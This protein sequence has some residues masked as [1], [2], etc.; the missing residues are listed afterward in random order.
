MAPSPS[1]LTTKRSSALFSTRVPNP[2][3]IG[4]SSLDVESGSSQSA[5]T[6]NT[7]LSFIVFENSTVG[8]ASVIC[9]FVKTSVL[10]ASICSFDLFSGIFAYT[11]VDT[12]MCPF[13]P[14]KLDKSEDGL[15]LC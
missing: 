11:P 5:N 12:T 15:F 4:F 8:K 2:P 1:E 14:T 10:P 9:G 6:P 13:L 3:Y 7:F